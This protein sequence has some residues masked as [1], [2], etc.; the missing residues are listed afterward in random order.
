MNV[1][2]CREHMVAT[3]VIIWVTTSYLQVSP[4]TPFFFQPSCKRWYEHLGGRTARRPRPQTRTETCRFVAGLII[5]PL[6]HEYTVDFS[7][8][9]GL[10]FLVEGC[11]T[12]H[13]SLSKKQIYIFL[14]PHRVSHKPHEFS[15]KRPLSQVTKSHYKACVRT[16]K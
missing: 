3:N 11:Y 8:L 7:I 12:L 13:R 5:L 6:H 9:L 10:N 1:L 14:S 15:C 4:G 16:E 2:F